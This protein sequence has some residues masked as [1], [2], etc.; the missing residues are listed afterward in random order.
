MGAAASPAR[1]AAP[2]SRGTQP[3]LSLQLPDNLTLVS[4]QIRNREGEITGTCTSRLACQRLQGWAGLSGAYSISVD[5]LAPDGVRES[6]S[7]RFFAG[8]DER[9]IE[10]LFYPDEDGLLKGFAPSIEAAPIEGV[11]LRVTRWGSYGELPDLELVNG[12]KLPIYVVA[13]AGEVLLQV[14]EPSNSPRSLGSRCGSDGSEVLEV[15]PGAFVPAGAAPH[16]QPRVQGIYQVRAGYGVSMEQLV[17]SLVGR[18]VSLEVELDGPAPDLAGTP[19]LP[20]PWPVARVERRPPSRPPSSFSPAN[21]EGASDPGLARWL[22]LE[23]EVAGTLT[24]GAPRRYFRVRVPPNTELAAVEFYARCQRPPCAGMAYAVL[25]NPRDAS[26]VSD[27]RNL[28]TSGGWTLIEDERARP[29]Q[30]SFLLV[31]G[32]VDG[33]P[34]PVQFFGRV[35]AWKNDER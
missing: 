26:S 33:C 11:A 12:S 17:T 9:A 32:C 3:T 14:D 2:R 13:R 24:P 34:G 5:Y 8:Y 22:E 10:L 27:A 25:N 16:K 31:V 23:Q 28:R 6:F 20:S 19:S 15:A 1:R 35:H 29:T 30:D 7:E 18:E 4:A 21:T